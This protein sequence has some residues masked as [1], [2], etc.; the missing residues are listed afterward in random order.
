[1]GF[2]SPAVL[3]K[4]A[5]RH[6]LRVKPIDVQASEWACTI[7]NEDNGALSLR[8]RLRYP[9]VGRSRTTR[10]LFE[11]K[12]TDAARPHRCVEPAR[13]DHASPRCSVAGRTC[14]Q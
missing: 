8:M 2:Y 4:D 14:W 7:E 5:Q 11:S 3:V 6:G 1:M 12:G 9:G 13:W 10:T